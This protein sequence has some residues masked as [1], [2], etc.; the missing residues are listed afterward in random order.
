MLKEVYR[1]KL[2]QAEMEYECNRAKLALYKAQINP[3][4][5]FNTLNTLYGLLITLSDKTEVTLEHF[6][7]L[8]KYMY[9]NAN[10][11]FIPLAEE[12]DY[13]GQYIALQQLQLNEL[14][15]FRFYTRCGKGR[16]SYSSYDA[17]HIRGKCV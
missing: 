5:P 12:V 4:F 16:N 10:W 8:T 7:N 1:Q 9:N 15:D 14:A 13:I 11:E 17:Y 2:A 6:I 3:H